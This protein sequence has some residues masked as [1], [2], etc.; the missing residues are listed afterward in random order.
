MLRL[1][2]SGITRGLFP[3]VEVS[4]EPGLL[5]FA[6]TL[7]DYGAD[8]SPGAS[9]S[10]EGVCQTVTRFADGVAHFD[11]IQETL[12]KTSLGELEVGLEVS[13]ERS[14]R[15]GDEL[16][17]HEV[18]GHVTG[19]GRLIERVVEGHEVRLRVQV[20]KDWMRFILPKGFIALDGSSFTVGAELG[21]DSFDVF[22]IP[23]TLR[24]TRL[25]DKPLGARI[26]VEL[27][28]KTVA[29][30]HTVERVLASRQLG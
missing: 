28:P 13:V 15:F 6:V 24:L 5:R 20:L 21:E 16:G 12:D 18:S 30:V 26:N 4:R 22:L 27:D 19:T 8:L 9:V 7:G 10:I 23:E 14:A 25:G 2:F 29:I 3:V 1:M 11:A 17:G